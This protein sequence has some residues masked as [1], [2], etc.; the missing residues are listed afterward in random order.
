MHKKLF[1]TLISIVSLTSYSWLNAAPQDIV[2]RNDAFIFLAN[3]VDTTIPES[4]QYINLKYTD[5]IKDSLLEDALQKLV[6]LNLIKNVSTQI[7]PNK[8][9]DLYT[10]EWLVKNILKLKISWNQSLSEKKSNFLREQDLASLNETLQT[11]TSEN[12]ITIVQTSW[13]TNSVLWEKETIFNDVFNTITSSY[14]DRDQVSK[15]QLVESAIKWLADWVWDKYTS[16]FPAIESSDFFSWLNGEFE[17]IGAYIEMNEPGKLIII[18]PI[19]GSPAEMAWLRAWDQVISVDWKTVTPQNSLAELVSWIKGPAG[20]TTEITVLRKSEEKK[21][22]VKRDTITIHN[23]EHRKENSD[24]YYIQI[25]TFWDNVGDE[26]KNAIETLAKDSSIKN[27]VIDVRNNPGWY[28]D[29][30]SLILSYFVPQGSA[31]AIVSN[32]Q[33]DIKYTSI[34][35][36]TINPKDYNIILLQNAWSASASEILVWTLKDYFPESIIIWEKSFGKGSVQSLK[37]Y[38]DGS[39]LKYTSAKWYTW[40]NKNWID[41]VGIQPDITIEFDTELFKTQNIDNQLQEALKY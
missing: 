36:E 33:K 1:Y 21:F 38:S 2:N 13:N 14:Y 19:A 12:P 37:N 28:L 3:S 40:K 25:K 4:F 31:T 17:G 35:L 22:K 6:Y 23:I 29:E 41:G 16:Y 26:F 15:E 27:I 9:V 7:V 32:G 30:A 5:V 39:T 8:N 34:G 11:K 20:T 10:F 24:T 18:S